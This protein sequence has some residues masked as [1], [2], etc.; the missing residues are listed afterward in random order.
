MQYA[1]LVVDVHSLNS[2][3]SAH[4][5]HPARVFAFPQPPNLFFLVWFFVANLLFFCLLFLASFLF[6]L[7]GLFWNAFLASPF[8]G[9]LG[10]C[11]IRMCVHGLVGG[12]SLDG[13]GSHT[14]SPGGNDQQGGRGQWQGCFGGRRISVP[15]GLR[16]ESGLGGQLA[17]PK[18][19]HEDDRP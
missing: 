1:I 14:G 13:G 6:G 11:G 17:G 8:R 15:A 10:C 18:G 4:S 7:G 2:A 19:L 12:G 3:H 16:R 9:F 5:A